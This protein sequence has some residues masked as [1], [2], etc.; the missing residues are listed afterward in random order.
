MLPFSHLTFPLIPPCNHCPKRDLVVFFLRVNEKTSNKR[1]P[2]FPG[3]EQ[4]LVA[5]KNDLKKGSF[6][7]IR[8]KPRQYQGFLPSFTKKPRS[9]GL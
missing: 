2:P 1:R 5:L 6:L 7:K 4:P 3:L 9:G 8:T